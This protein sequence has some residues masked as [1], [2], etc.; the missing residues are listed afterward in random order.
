MSA[1]KRQ[2]GIDSTR[3]AG[4]DFDTASPP[5]NAKQ[6]GAGPKVSINDRPAPKL[7]HERDEGPPRTI[8]GTRRVVKQAAR[9]LAQGMTDTS[10]NAETTDLARKLRT[11]RSP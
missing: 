3:E 7:P 1:S 5:P 10:R 4:R 6:A 2:S 9:D 8:P 11:D